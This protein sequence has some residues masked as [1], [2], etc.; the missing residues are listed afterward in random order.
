MT[1]DPYILLVEDNPGDIHLVQAMFEDAPPGTLPELHW[2]QSVRAAS[3][4]LS[5]QRGCTALLLDLALPDSHGLEALAAL[6][7]LAADVP[8]IV[9]SGN[10]DEDV[11]LSAVVNGAQDYLVKGAFDATLLRRALQY[12]SHRKRVEQELVKRAM[13]DHLTGLPTRALM[14]D[15]L[16]MALNSAA[17]GGNRGALL[18]VDLDRF[19]EVNDK[20]GHAAG[21]AVLRASAERMLGTIRASD[22]VSRIGGDE[23]VILLPVIGADEG[24]HAVA[25]KIL[26]TLA[27]PISVAE[28]QLSISASIGVIEFNPGESTAEEL[29]EQ[30]D[31]AMYAA[32][33][34]GRSAVHQTN[35]LPG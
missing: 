6:R 15:R 3:A 33:R 2:E 18:F 29:V 4:H 11:G 8:I 17:R 20:Y 14:L 21:D 5:K 26:E 27:L 24:G 9:L 1:S 32:K 31:Q 28:H 23:F 25:Q 22:T 13:H 16:R 35:V 7:D 19:K 34:A 12:A 30:A 10:D